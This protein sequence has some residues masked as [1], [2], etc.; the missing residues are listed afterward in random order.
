MPLN[1]YDL[2][3]LFSNLFDK[4]VVFSAN[5]TQFSRNPNES[6]CLPDFQEFCQINAN[7]FF[8]T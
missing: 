1:L 2:R 5:S 7:E 4:C 8:K 3:S 6:L